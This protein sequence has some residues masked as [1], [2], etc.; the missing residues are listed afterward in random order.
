M[1]SKFK[2]T[3]GILSYN[4]PNELFRAIN[5]L[6][7]L[8]KDV[9]VLICDDKS[10]KLDEILISINDLL[11]IENLHF[12]SNENNLGYDRNLYRVIELASSEHVMLLGDD[13]YLED[14]AL[15]NILAFLALKPD[16]HCGFVH[17][18]NNSHSLKDIKYSRDYSS[19]KYFDNNMLEKDGSFIYTAI[20]FSGLIFSKKSIELGQMDFSRYYKSIYIQVAIFVKLSLKFGSHYINGPGVI[21]GGDG[22]SGFGFNEASDNID[23]DLKDRSSVI[24]NLSYHKRLYDVVRNLQDET[25]I[26]I[27]KSFNSEYKIRSIKAFYLAREYGRKYLWE[28]WKELKKVNVQNIWLFYPIYL[29]I[30]CFPTWILNYPIFIIEKIINNYRSKKSKKYSTND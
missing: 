28:Y 10:P 27:L 18:R 21:I 20:L 19:H 8:P 13:D 14:G 25:K 24:S 26:N 12:I 23:S 4:R 2:L 29:I 9:E 11:I 1:N 22:E 30:F 7:P 5:S 16:F 15:Q 6:L 17:F 3:I